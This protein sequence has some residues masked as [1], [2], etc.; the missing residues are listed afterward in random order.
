[1]IPIRSTVAG[2]LR[3][4]LGGSRREGPHLSI[5]AGRG[6]ATMQLLPCPAVGPVDDG[7]PDNVWP[8]DPDHVPGWLLAR[9]KRC[10][11]IGLGPFKYR[12]RRE[13]ERGI[14]LCAAALEPKMQAA[15]TLAPQLPPAEAAKAFLTWLRVNAHTGEHTDAELRDLYAEHCTSANVAPSP[16]AT[17]RKFLAQLGGVNKAMKEAGKNGAHRKRGTVWIIKPSLAKVVEMKAA[18]AAPKPQDLAVAA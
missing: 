8:D 15:P 3:Q 9:E 1:M 11:A 7:L 13:Y 10:I 18:K 4:R 6:E 16:E 17:M 2:W 5:Q 14:E 12:T